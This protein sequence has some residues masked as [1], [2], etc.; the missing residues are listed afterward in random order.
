MHHRAAVVCWVL[1]LLFGGCGVYCG[2]KDPFFTSEGIGS[3]ISSLAAWAGLGMGFFLVIAGFLLI[4]QI[5]L[6]LAL[7][8]LA[9]FI[10]AAMDVRRDSYTVV[11]KT[12]PDFVSSRCWEV[13]FA[14]VAVSLLMSLPLY[15]VLSK[16]RSGGVR[17]GP[18]NS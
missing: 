11:G 15:L 5:V 12:G 1:A 16:W 17:R 3:G 2:V 13:V 9:V 10:S 18:G 4:G 7:V 6:S 14:I 8:N